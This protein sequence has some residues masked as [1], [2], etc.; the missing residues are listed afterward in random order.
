MEN[1]ENKHDMQ[2]SPKNEGHIGKHSLAMYKRFAIMAVVMF[3][4]MYFIMYAMIDG[5]SNLIPNVNNLYMTLLMVSAMLII[6][7]WIMK[8]MYENQKINWGIIIISAATGIFSW[9]GIREQINVGD[10]QFV[11]GM[12]P[13]HA[14]AVL[15]SE[16]AKLTDPELIQLQKN[17][18]K[19][20]S[21]EIEFMKRKLKELENK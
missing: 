20:Q 12:I 1:M 10:K 14:A 16:K 5:L 4:A 11:K 18:L 15:M 3:A 2:H 7:I 21:E 8:S 17:I 19:T 13:H 6:E 9:F